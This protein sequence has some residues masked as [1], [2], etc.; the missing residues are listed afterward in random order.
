MT[1]R[2]VLVVDDE[3]QIHEDFRR[4]LEV[5]TSGN[6]LDWDEDQEQLREEP[7]ESFLIDSAHQGED[8]YLRVRES[9]Q[10]GLPYAVA[11]VD[12]RM[13]PG[14]D[15]LATIEHLWQADPELQVVI[16]TAY[17]DYSWRDI[18]RR[19]GGN[20]RLLI[21][22]KPFEPVEIRQ[23]AATLATKRSL[24]DQTRKRTVEL[25]RL[26]QDH[27]RA[28]QEAQAQNRRQ[29]ELLSIAQS[30]VGVILSQ[31]SRALEG[32][33]GADDA[34]QA[35]A[36]SAQVMQEAFEAQNRATDT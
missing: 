21:I 11:F 19:L 26:A 18:T 15:G 1:S 4:I 3:P 20:D 12:M 5:Q 30:Q 17:A 13:P 6:D 29:G 8:A 25:A 16:C 32:S 24:A 7:D 28:L 33:S 10:N 27:M 23:A 14:W 22:K 9:I 35:I 34:L 36:R 31:T 2:R